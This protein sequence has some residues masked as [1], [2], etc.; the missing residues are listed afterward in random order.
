MFH[1]YSHIN[2]VMMG[3]QAVVVPSP[4]LES[5]PIGS[6]LGTTAAGK[7]GLSP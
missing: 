7:F 4:K 6:Y 1:L 2:T 3:A 5:W